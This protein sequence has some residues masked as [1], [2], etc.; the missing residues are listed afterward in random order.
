MN[1]IYIVVMKNWMNN[2][3]VANTNVNLFSLGKIKMFTTSELIVGIALVIVY[4][5]WGGRW[6][7]LHDLAL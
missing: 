6:Q 7:R 1:I 3:I 4:W 5:W 2:A